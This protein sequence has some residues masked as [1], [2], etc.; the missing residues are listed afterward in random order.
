MKFLAKDSAWMQ[1]ASNGEEL[2]TMM[3]QPEYFG[4]NRDEDLLSALAKIT[5]HVRREKTETHRAFFNP[6][7]Q[8]TGRWLNIGSSYQTSTWDS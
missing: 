4:D 5:Y 8:H 1:S 2:I 6:W 3:D 7:R